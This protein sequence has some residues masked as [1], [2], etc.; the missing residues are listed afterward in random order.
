MRQ[1]HAPNR[2]RRN[3][4]DLH[5]PRRATTSAHAADEGPRPARAQRMSNEA[6]RGDQHACSCTASGAALYTQCS[7]THS[8]QAH[9]VVKHIQWTNTYS[10]QTHTVVK[11]IQWTNTYSD[12]T[13]TVVKHIQWS[14][15]YSGQTHTVVKH[16]QWSS[17]YSG[18]AHTVVKHI[19]CTKWSKLFI[20]QGCSCA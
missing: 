8:G 10:D 6:M 5:R 19:H 14:N 9:T 20:R 18:Q 15:T 1:R 13:H 7:S 17:T 11:H 12:Q 16:I 2:C 3:C 4:N